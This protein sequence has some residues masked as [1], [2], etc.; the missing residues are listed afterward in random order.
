MRLHYR[1]LHRLLFVSF[2]GLLFS[3]LLSFFQ[4]ACAQTQVTGAQIPE[5]NIGQIIYVAKHNPQA[6]DSNPGTPQLP[7]KTIGKAREIA[8]VYNTNN[9]GTK[10][11]ISPGYYRE[12]IDVW[13]ATDAPIIFEAMRKGQVY[14]A[15][16]DVWT[17]WQRQGNA[18]IYTHP[19][20]YDWGLVDVPAEWL[21][22]PLTQT[23]LAPIVRRRE[24]IFV[25]GTS[26]RQVLSYAEL[27]EKSFYVDETLDTVYIWPPAG[28]AIETANIEV[29]VR[30]VLFSAL[31]KANIVLRGLVFRH[32]NNPFETSAVN[33]GTDSN[34]L[35]ED[36]QFVWNNWGGLGIGSSEAV[37]VR[38]SVANYNGGIGMGAAFGKNFLFEDNETSY[39]NWR[40][41]RAGY[42][43]WSIAGL[44]HLFIHSAIYRRHKAVNN[45]T[46]GFWLDTDNTNISVEE[47]F[48]HNNL[49]FGMFIEANQG[50]ITVKD[51]T[52]CHNKDAGFLINNS[53]GV[54][55]AHNIIYGN[56]RAQIL[57]EGT[58]PEG[59]PVTNWETGEDI[60]LLSGEWTLQDN[61][62]VGKDASQLLLEINLGGA[63]SQAW[64]TFVDSLTSEENVWYN[65]ASHNVFKVFGWSIQEKQVDFT[66][67][68]A[69]TGQDLDSVFANPQFVNPDNHQ[70]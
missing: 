66:E 10:I 33:F 37:T 6:S 45:Q 3:L 20:P 47:A 43:G 48:L 34:I 62:I 52:I 35:V 69:I 1:C 46:L 16:S 54:T 65:P 42:I 7:L 57:A 50:P 55:L 13:Q 68:Q 23:A 44:K 36:C 41:I 4:A 32:A 40:G 21:S 31:E 14:I 39:N 9:I 26:L 11:L 56:K 19:W 29:A 58:P 18:N 25:N 53:R 61:D 22:D 38:R 70:F 67:W 49:S 5:E 24:M 30:P 64:T 28:T 63:D 8:L 2:I 12:S 15:G 27:S 51:S 17:G 59:R 60:M